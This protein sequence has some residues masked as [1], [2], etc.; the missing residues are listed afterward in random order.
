M[1]IGTKNNLVNSVVYSVVLPLYRQEDHID[2]IVYEYVKGLESQPLSWELILVINGN[3][4]NAF[5]KAKYYSEN[6]KRIVA[7]ELRQ[8][9][10]GKAV[11]YGMTAAKGKCLCY[12]NSARTQI[13]DLLLILNYAHVNPK[14]VVKATRIVRTN[15]IRKIGSVIYN[16]QNRI[17]FQTA[18]MDVN[19]TPKIFPRDVWERLKVVSDGDLIDAE[20]IAKCFKMEILVLE[21]P[22]R[23][24]NRRTG[25]STTR[26]SSAI[27]MY[28]GLFRL[29]AKIYHET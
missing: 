21:V 8:G 26:I 28:S 24:T 14:A 20:V 12:T 9:G 10:W 6:D 23:I 27:K 22:V 29:Y 17:L 1:H 7:L 13:K 2:N 4:D 16:F 11:K 18:I 25:E 5:A 15:F 19:G 3:K